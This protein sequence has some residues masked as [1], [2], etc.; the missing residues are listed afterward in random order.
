V[1]SAL[2]SFLKLSPLPSLTEL[3]DEFTGKPLAFFALNLSILTLLNPV[4][5]FI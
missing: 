2:G 4:A 5:L 3:P 1:F